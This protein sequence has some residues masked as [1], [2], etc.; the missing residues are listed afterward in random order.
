MTHFW[1]MIESLLIYEWLTTYLRMTHFWFMIESLLIYE[2]LTSDLRMTHF[3]FTNDSLLIYEWLTPDLRMTH[4]WFTND[5]PLIYEWLTSDLRMTH[6]WLRMTPFLSERP[7]IQ[8]SGILGNVCWILVSTDTAV[9]S[10]ATSCFPRLYNFHSR[11]L[12][13]FV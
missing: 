8:R 1:F 4:F 7:L 13:N 6:L 11:I 5:S 10:T 3:W 2:W 12:G 9:V